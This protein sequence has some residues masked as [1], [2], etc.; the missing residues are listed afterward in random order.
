MDAVQ[1][2]AILAALSDEVRGE[3]QRIV[4]QAVRRAR[5]A[6]YC[7]QF[8]AVMAQIMPEMTIDVGGYTVAVD[9]DG[10]P[11]ASRHEDAWSYYGA[12]DTRRIYDADGYDQHGFDRDGF[13]RTGYDVDGFDANDQGRSRSRTQRR[14]RWV[15][16]NGR[17]QTRAE[18]VYATGYGEHSCR[19]ANGNLRPGRPATAEETAAEAEPLERYNPTTWAPAPV[20]AE[21]TVSA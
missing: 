19:D 17:E 13:D 4:D 16:E 2:Q 21:Q 14:T 20:A 3:R 10:R 12:R 8:N 5:G 11:C 1:S 18:R 9:S 15:D 6:G 7:E